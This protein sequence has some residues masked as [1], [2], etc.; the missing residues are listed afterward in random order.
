METI[1]RESREA[2]LRLHAYAREIGA[3][4]SR[5]AATNPQLFGSAARGDATVTSDIDL[6][7]DLAPGCGNELLRVAGLSEELGDLLG[8]RVDV[9]TSSLLRDG[10]AATALADAVPL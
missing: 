10:V 8:C 2:Q 7:V 1:T 3:I 5:Y 6:M 4:L 9:V